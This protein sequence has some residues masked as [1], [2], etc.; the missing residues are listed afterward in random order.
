MNYS[1]LSV[2]YMHDGRLHGAAQMIELSKLVGGR[3]HRGGCLL[4]TIRLLHTYTS[5][6]VELLTYHIREERTTNLS[7]F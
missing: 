3:L 1:Q 2:A 6:R 7:G 4:R 5:P